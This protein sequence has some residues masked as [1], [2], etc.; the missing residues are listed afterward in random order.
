[1]RPWH[2]GADGLQLRP[3]PRVGP[4]EQQEARRVRPLGRQPGRSKATQTAGGLPSMA[5]GGLP[6]WA[7]VLLV[8]AAASVRRAT[9]AAVRGSMASLDDVADAHL[10]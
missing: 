1:L 4:Q 3:G 9:A 7:A 2:T 8:R 5:V 10:P 6:S